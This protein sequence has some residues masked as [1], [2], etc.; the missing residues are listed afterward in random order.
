M[1]AK[2]ATGGMEVT[3]KNMQSANYVHDL[4][5][6]LYLDC[7]SAFN[8]Q[9]NPDTICSIFYVHNYW[10]NQYQQL[11]S[12]FSLHLSSSNTFSTMATYSL[13]SI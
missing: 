1:L 10:N 11:V 13:K 3:L 4:G 5:D 7:F 2:G 9:K 6:A 8:E 12:N